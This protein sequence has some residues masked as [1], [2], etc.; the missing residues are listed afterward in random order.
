MT[1]LTRRASQRAGGSDRQKPVRKRSSLKANALYQELFASS[2]DGILLI[3]AETQRVVE[4]NDAAC[5]QLGYTREEFARLRISDY[6]ASETPEETAARVHKALREGKDEFDTVQR[7]KTGQIRHVHVW[8]QTCDLDGRVVFYAIFRDITERKEAEEALRESEKSLQEAQRLA[9]VGSWQ[10]TVATDTVK[11]S[12]ELSHINGH[13]PAF[14]APSFAG[15]STHYTPE[16][17]KRLS[18]VVAKALRSGESYELD[19]EIVRPDGTRRH[20][21]ARGQADHDASGKIVGLH[22]TV[23]DITE[24]KR[25][26]A[27][28]GKLHR[29]VESSG[30]VIF[31]T[32]RDGIF[33]Y[34]NPM[35]AK[36]YG[37]AAAEVVGQATPRIL[38][39]G[40]MTP[41][42]YE[43][44]WKTLLSGQVVEGEIVNKTKD[45]RTIDIENSANP[46]F[47]DRG[48]IVGFLCVQRNITERKR[49]EEA[50]RR[51]D[52]IL[53]AVG[54]A[55]G[56]F[57][58]AG[59][60]R[61]TIGSVLARLGEATAVSR[62]VIFENQPGLGDE[63]LISRR[64]E[65]R[66]AGMNARSDSALTDLTLRAMG[67]GRWVEVLSA[68]Q[69]IFQHVR[70]L[71]AGEQQALAAQGILSVAVVPIFVEGRWW[72]F[73]GFDACATECAWGELESEALFTAARILGEAITRE[74]AE[75]TRVQLEAQ[76]RQAQK[77]ESVGQL[78]SGIAHDFNNLLTVIN[79]MSDLV[80]EQVS[81]DDP[82]PADV[83]EIHRAGERAAALTRQ[84]LAF[85]RQQILEPRVLSLNTVVA[86]MES[87]LRRLLGEDIDLVVGPTRD[88]RHVKADPGQVEQ[89]ISNLAVNARD[90][91]PHGGR[92]TIETQN[93][94]ID[95]DDARQHGVAVP[96]GPYVMLSVADSGVGMDEATRARIFEPFFTTKGPGKGTGLGLSTVYGI[97]QQSHGFIR[98]DSEVGQGTSFKIYLPQVTEAGGTDRLEPTVVSSSGTETILL[99]EDN[100]GL[101]KLATRLLEPAG[102][103]VLGAATGEEALRLL[104]GHE[105]N[106]HLLLSDVVM[107]GMSGRQ[108]AEQLAQTRPGMKVLYM[109][110]YTGD[111][112]VR[113]GVLEAQVSFLNKPFTAAA[114]L[115]KIREVL[116]S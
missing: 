32:D 93:V 30:E 51:R 98:V 22:G 25:A 95:E 113:H 91:M 73:I 103:T 47:D 115:R 66:A 24:R 65:W 18:A 59:D 58:H 39:S 87:L 105:K 53:S 3:D 108:L 40:V 29:A 57:L 70:D 99:V 94:E 20:T 85:S 6:E 90:A 83:Q 112:I 54:L 72:G 97:V 13:D 84:L 10:W 74:H 34:V 61:Q 37:F 60:W 35:F 62:V 17:W 4:F 67:F 107:P 56:Q 106:V 77:M 52:G 45:G 50:L 101:R 21:S 63:I 64:H 100:A 31:L 76:F 80:L 38:K 79:G 116:D 44:F 28:I 23:Q 7:A 110:G 27:E 69:G 2:P 16:S 46:V 109:S 111:T 75:T 68:G 78:A 36:V 55:A 102:Y 49:T 5:R 114:L 43:A 82:V 19:L 86:G 88:L 15:M 9:H 42:A 8:T 92:L 14:P 104:E 1:K 89:V 81:S 12:E 26:E 41:Q 33:T 96:L 71:P 11:W 48:N